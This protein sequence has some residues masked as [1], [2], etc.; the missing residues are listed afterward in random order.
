M[1]EDKTEY[2]VSQVPEERLALIAGWS[3][4]FGNNCTVIF[5]TKLIKVQTFWY[6]LSPEEANAFVTGYEAGV[7]KG[8]R[9][10]EQ[11]KADKIKKLLGI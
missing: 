4:V 3:C 2:K 5:D 8:C 10:G 7:E 6:R 11:R 9:I 1:S